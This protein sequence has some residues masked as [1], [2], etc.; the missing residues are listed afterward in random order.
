MAE[1]IKLCC[2]EFRDFI[3]FWK[4]LNKDKDFSAGSAPEENT[5]KPFNNCPYCGS[6][7]AMSAEKIDRSKTYSIKW[8]NKID[9]GIPW[10]DNQH[11]KLL[12]RLNVLLNAVVH[13]KGFEETGKSITFLKEY[14]KAHF[15]TEE[16]LMQKH[17]FP[18]RETQK[19]QHKYFIEKM[20]KYVDDYAQG[21][22]S[23]ELAVKVAKE[24]WEWFKNHI[25]QEDIKFGEFLKANSHGDNREPESIMEDLLKGAG[26]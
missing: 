1:N 4:T 17:K 12:E 10:I 6:K 14:T 8:D 5:Y 15:G 25:T 3:E 23:K 16:S 22:A 13:D 19:K 2:S 9:T 20:D 7:I 26:Q 11:K 18:G 21:G 24:L